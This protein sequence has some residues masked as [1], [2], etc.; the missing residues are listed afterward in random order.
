MTEP[1]NPPEPQNPPSPPEPPKY[2]PVPYAEW[3]AWHDKTQRDKIR[4][5]AAAPFVNALKIIGITSIIPAVLIAW[6]AYKGLIFEQ[7]SEA[8]RQE[9]PLAMVRTDAIIKPAREALTAQLA[10]W[11]KQP[12][13]QREIF[14]SPE[15]QSQVREAARTVLAAEITTQANEQVVAARR[16]RVLQEGVPEQVRLGVLADM[17]DADAEGA[18]LTDSVIEL[19]E[20]AAALPPEAENATP[21]LA[22]ALSAARTAVSLMAAAGETDGHRFAP[23][24]QRIQDAAAVLCAQA[25]R[26]MPGD[27]AADLARI[28]GASEPRDRAA[29]TAKLQRWLRQALAAADGRAYPVVCADALSTAAGQLGGAAALTVA[30]DLML[31]RRPADARA[32]LR[33]FADWRAVDGDRAEPAAALAAFEAALTTLGRLL[34]EQP[35]PHLARGAARGPRIGW[36]L[37]A[38]AA[39]TGRARPDMLRHADALYPGAAQGLPSAFLRYLDRWRL[40]ECVQEEEAPVECGADPRSLGFAEH[41][42]ARAWR[43]SAHWLRDA[44]PRLLRA[45]R[46]LPPPSREALAARLRQRLEAGI[47]QWSDS[48][49]DEAEDAAAL[50]HAL[51]LSL[52][53]GLD[54][55][56]SLA[57]GAG[58]LAHAPG[59]AGHPSMQY[60]LREVALR[61]TTPDAALPLVGALLGPPERSRVLDPLLAW[62]LARLAAQ[63]DA[64]ADEQAAGALEREP[65]AADRRLSLAMLTAWATGPRALTAAPATL[66]AVGGPAAPAR[67]AGPQSPTALEDGLI[68]AAAEELAAALDRPPEARTLRL[69]AALSLLLRHLDPRRADASP[70]A[71]PDLWY[72]LLR[73]GLARP[74]PDSAPRPLARLHAEIWRVYAGADLSVAGD[75]EPNA[76][77]GPS[78]KGNTVLR[79]EIP[80]GMTGRVFAELAR[81][82]QRATAS[83]GDAWHLVAVDPSART[84]RAVRFAPGP[85]GGAPGTSFAIA[86]EGQPRT[87]LLR[88]VGGPETDSFHLRA[89]LAAAIEP[90][91]VAGP[92]DAATLRALATAQLPDPPVVAFALPAGQTSALLRLDLPQGAWLD[93]ETLSP[94]GRDTVIELL[95]LDAQRLGFDDDSGSGDLLSRLVYRGAPR[96]VVLRFGLYGG[97]LREDALFTARI[98]VRAETLRPL[99]A[100]QPERA[101]L[102]REEDQLVFAADLPAGAPFTVRTGALADGL[103]S[104]LTLIRPDG[105]EMAT[106]DDGGGGLASCIAFRTTMA[107]SHRF[108]VRNLRPTAEP[109]GFTLLLAPDAGRGCAGP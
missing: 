63:A 56:A 102:T 22:F 72:G 2:V 84:I 109:L 64:A 81:D 95:G 107:G 36:M 11:V 89:E 53:A 86:A 82:G 28:F 103:D 73:A 60:A 105:A 68:L 47:R 21:A 90:S 9:L 23:L 99:A 5:E 34:A 33:L 108:V 59:L 17:L 55:G 52:L 85:G 92:P 39:L 25:G 91:I 48:P 67:G 83:A 66:R 35:P 31:E 79:L 50:T 41:F 106:D 19:L 54:P 57:V 98:V 88:I 32:A 80:P 37:T 18:R 10:E 13:A 62:L 51:E 29:Q 3:Q 12:A 78:I 6:S 24:W 44:P 15:L 20:R 1:P 93:A 49:V 76:E 27:A 45:A 7:A 4:A 69:A 43:L 58:L 87:L 75:I 38:E 40:A 42:E 101:E 30:R 77:P 104:V 14:D 8:V 26:R 65:S 16:R 94:R 70:L 100:G 71:A 46:A 61:Q 74:A 96:S 97:E